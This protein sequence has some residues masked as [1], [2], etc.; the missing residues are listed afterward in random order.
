MNAQEKDR[1]LSGVLAFAQDRQGAGYAVKDY[2][3]DMLG[4]LQQQPGVE[5]VRE[6]QGQ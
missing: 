5:N 2:A 3:P 6:L 1:I 4:Y